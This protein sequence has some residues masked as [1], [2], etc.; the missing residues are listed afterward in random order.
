MGEGTSPSTFCRQGPRA[1][2]A[3]HGGQQGAGVGVARVAVKLVGGGGLD[4]LAQIH[5]RDP[6]ADLADRAQVVRDE[7]QGDIG[8]GLHLP[9]QV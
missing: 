9:E 1:V 2:N 5:D 7:Q 8:V 4:D 3:R 6:V